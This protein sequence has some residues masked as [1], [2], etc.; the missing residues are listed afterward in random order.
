MSEVPLS[1]ALDN[2]EFGTI[3]VDADGIVTF[4]S[5]SYERFLGIPRDQALGRHVAEVIENTRMHSVVQ[6]GE[7][8][9]G[10]RHKIRGQNMVVQRVPIRDDTGKIIGAVG[11]V[12][13]RDVAEITELA[14]KLNLL[15]SKLELYERELEHLRSSRYTF[16]HI[17]GT[18]PALEQVKRLALK[19]AEGNSTVLLL[20]ESGVGK[21]LF[22]HAIHHASPRRSKPFV[23]VNCSSIPH[24]LMESELFGYEAGA[25]TGA[26]RK[27][28]PGKFELANQ[29]SIFLDE[30]GDMPLEMQSKLLRVLQEKEVERVG[31]TKMLGVDFRLIAATNADP[32]ELVKTGRLRRDLFYRLNVV[33]I[34]I[35]SLRE[36][37][38]DIPAISRHLMTR[39]REQQGVRALDISTEVMDLF[40]RYDWPGNI[41]ELTNVLER[42]SYAA[43]GLRIEIEHLPLFLREVRGARAGEK[44]R[45]NLREALKEVE[46]DAVL[47]A[48][49][50]TNGNKA[51]AAKLLGIHRTGL[52]QKLA[53]L[54]VGGQVTGMN[55]L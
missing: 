14:Q 49:S 28:K 15:E 25:F 38:E 9:I 39:L 51:K 34:R 31:G 18:S 45:S 53:R 29:G 24:E 5:K 10:W 4:F 6:S 20:G 54:K 55:I 30:V 17:I 8:E 35:P 21:E 13:F 26:G 50:M 43:E 37:R 23:R 40:Q 33:P 2:I 1:M 52:Y 47:R 36:R 11:Q 12:M 46:R 48:L 7:P 32:E 19:A 42:A 16:D 41:R 27:G 3:V 22:A 44:R